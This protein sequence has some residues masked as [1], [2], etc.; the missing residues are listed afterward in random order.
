MDSS[1]EEPIILGW[2]EMDML[3]GLITPDTISNNGFNLHATQAGE[4]VLSEEPS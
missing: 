4:I 1:A 3:T 2:V